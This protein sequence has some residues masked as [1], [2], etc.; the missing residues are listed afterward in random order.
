MVHYDVL[1]LFTERRVVELKGHSNLECSCAEKNSVTVGG[2]D[3][4]VSQGCIG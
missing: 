4:L 2:A 1:Q 3:F